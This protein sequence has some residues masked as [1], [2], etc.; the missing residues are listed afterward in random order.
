M[1]VAL[2]ALAARIIRQSAVSWLTFPRDA[3]GKG[4]TGDP[5]TYT[6]L[7]CTE[8][9]WGGDFGARSPPTPRARSLGLEQRRWINGS[10][11]QIT[12]KNKYRSRTDKLAFDQLCAG[13]RWA[14]CP[15]STRV[16][17]RDLRRAQ[18]SQ[19]GVLLNS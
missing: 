19:A 9:V 1:S 15:P 11:V 8:L 5:P 14:V 2:L 16:I 13:C 18:A 10:L 12:T 17:K 4:K 3:V 6:A 7:R